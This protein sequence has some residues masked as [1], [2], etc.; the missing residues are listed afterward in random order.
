M[1]YDTVLDLP[2]KVFSLYNSQVTKIRAE[3][4]MRLLSL[5][6]SSQSKEGVEKTYK[7][8]QNE[9]GE[10]IKE[11]KSHKLIVEPEEGAFEKLKMLGR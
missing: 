3:K 11:T 2:L 8:L 9:L 5:L 6:A 10:P 4:D 7:R 1:D